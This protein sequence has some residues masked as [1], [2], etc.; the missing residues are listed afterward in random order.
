MPPY[1]N[2]DKYYG[3]TLSGYSDKI[4]IELSARTEA[5]KN[6]SW[7]VNDAKSSKANI[8]QNENNNNSNFEENIRQSEKARALA[9]E[10]K[11]VDGQLQGY[12]ALN[13]A[14]AAN[15]EKEFGAMEYNAEN[16]E[17]IKKYA[18]LKN[19]YAQNL[20]EILEEIRAG[21]L[22]EG[23]RA[24]L[25]QLKGNL[26][27]EMGKELAEGEK[28]TI[29]TAENINAGIDAFS[30]KEG[31]NLSSDKGIVNGRD[32]SFSNFIKI[33]KN[34]K[35]NVRFYF[36]KVSNNLAERIKNDIGLDVNGYNIAIRSSEVV[37]GLNQ[38]GNATKEALRGQIAVT[39]SEFEK[40]PNIF[41]NPDRIILLDK[42]DYAGRT[43]FEI[44]K[45]I[46][47]YMIAVIGVANGRHSIEIDSVRIVN[48]KRTVTTVN[49][50]ENN[51]NHT[52]ETSSD[53]FNNSI[54]DKNT[55][56]NEREKTLKENI[57]DDAAPEKQ[58]K[59]REIVGRYAGEKTIGNMDKLAKRLGSEVVYYLGDD[60][61]EGFYEN[62]KIYLNANLVDVEKN[63]GQNLVISGQQTE[64]GQN[65]TNANYWKI[66]KHEFTHA[67]EDSKAFKKDFTD[68]SLASGLYSDFIKKQGFIDEEGNAD[69][70]AYADSIRELYRKNGQELDDNGLNRELMDKF[71]QE[72][73][74]FENEESINRLVNENRGFGQRILDWIRNTLNKIKGVDPTAE[75]MLK[76]AERLYAKAVRETEKKG[77]RKSG[78]QNS[79]EEK[80]YDYS[81][82]FSQQIDDYKNGKIPEYDTLIVGKTPEVLKKIRFNDL[83][84]TINQKHIEYMLKNTK[85]ADHYIA[86]RQKRKTWNFK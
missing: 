48:K 26:I 9:E 42:K 74:L 56:I 80:N 59:Y 62:G 20:D 32:M 39:E 81:K 15:I 10:I 8:A 70:A 40:L 23:E 76:E 46:D 45:Q 16:L 69:K 5:L 11:K 82:S 6:A 73:D 22:Q 18:G 38:H 57:E 19:S 14:I 68:W 72:S 54:N 61:S 12:D 24:F 71:V 37:H 64:S 43:A 1:N 58:A 86:F 63:S 47:N 67:I 55:K 66:F 7:P 77:A 25:K 33:A 52:P 78:K 21:K 51:P 53:Q 17:K 35:N 41:E 30:E 4:E 34:I 50:A 44:H 65:S 79:I 28:S 85:D 31:N 27:N 2:A 84:V 29:Q 49:I 60:S 83:P 36:G 75:N 3:H 13:E